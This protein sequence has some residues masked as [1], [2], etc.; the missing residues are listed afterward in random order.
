M[1]EDCTEYNVHSQMDKIRHFIQLYH[2]VP[3][4]LDFKD[5]RGYKA[6]DYATWRFEQQTD[7]YME[8]IVELLANARKHRVVMQ[9]QPTTPNIVGHVGNP[10]PAL[11]ESASTQL[12]SDRNLT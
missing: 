8:C 3:F 11:L 5:W 1:V 9:M 7:T 4:V 10:C 2:E 6:V 12:G